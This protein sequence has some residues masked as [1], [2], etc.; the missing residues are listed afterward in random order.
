VGLGHVVDELEDEH[1]LAYAGATEQPDLAA[2]SIRREQV[3]HL[4]PGLEDFHARAL[5]DEG[6]RRAMDG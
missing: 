3:H 1:R 6:G 4:D 5:F 2:L